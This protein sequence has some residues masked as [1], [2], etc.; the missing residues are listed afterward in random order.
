LSRLNV[1]LAIAADGHTLEVLNRRGS[2]GSLT[3]AIDRFC[4]AA[5]LLGQATSCT[6]PTKASS[7]R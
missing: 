4:D 2:D 7:P 5:L 3:M 1:G 6:V